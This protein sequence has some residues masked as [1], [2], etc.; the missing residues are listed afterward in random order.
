MPPV[1]RES[2]DIITAKFGLIMVDSGQSAGQ[3]ASQ[4]REP[5][6]NKFFRAAIKTRASDLHL[7]AGQPARLRI[8]DELRSTTGETLSEERLEQL[9]F[10]IL[11]EEQRQSFARNGTLDFSYGVT[12]EDRFRVN[13]FRQ[14][15]KIMKDLTLI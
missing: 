11:S 7:K 2:R 14:R 3:D 9:T 10:E 12:E 6:I 8:Q 15:G 1:G 4:G 5:E 13:I